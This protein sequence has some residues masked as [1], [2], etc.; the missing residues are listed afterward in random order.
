MKNS[1]INN[2]NWRMVTLGEVCT[3]ISKGSTPTTYGHSFTKTG[4]PFVR[5]EDV[6][7]GAIDSNLVTFH[8]GQQTHDF[9][10]RS[11]LYSGDILITIAGTLGRVGYIPDNS[12]ELN[13]NQAVCFARPNSEVLYAPYACYALRN[14][15]LIDNLINQKAG[16]GVQNLNLEQIKSFCL[17][18]PNLEV[19]KRIVNLLDRKFATIDRVK[20]AAEEQLSIINMLEISI[21][22]EV[23]KL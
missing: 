12:S 2:G 4:I 21:F 7:G 5:A 9:L 17:P 19:Q 20:K 13:C 16:G 8:I 23:F 14:P 11:K 10:K 6:N 1:E 3:T 18:L 15:E 22:R